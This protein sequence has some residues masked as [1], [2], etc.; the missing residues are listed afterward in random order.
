MLRRRGGAGG[1][2]ASASLPPRLQKQLRRIQQA[3]WVVCAVSAVF[4]YLRWDELRELVRYNSSPIDW[5]EINYEVHPAIAEWYNS[6]S[7][8]PIA[9]VGPVGYLY[10]AIPERMW[11]EVPNVYLILLLVVL[12]GVG[13]F[14][15]HATLSVFGQIM[16]ELSIIWISIYGAFLV[17]KKRDHPLLV[18]A[19]FQHSVCLAMVMC[20]T[21]LA[22]FAPV[23]SHFFVLAS[24]PAG[25]FNY[26]CA[27]R[28]SKSPR[29][30]QMFWTSMRFFAAAWTCWLTDR[31]ACGQMQALRETLGFQPQLH[32]AWHLFVSVMAYKMIQVICGFR[33]EDDL[34]EDERRAAARAGGDVV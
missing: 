11:R 15:F 7:S 30:K 16:D 10:Q 23:V 1:D 13:S 22:L 24:A 19:V 6:F 5:C 2:A 32:A 4:A 25:V 29:M 34:A 21:L 20:T 12:I 27:Y 17:V 31:L 9:L 14:W 3:A 28:R 18:A 33:I 8:I 26:A